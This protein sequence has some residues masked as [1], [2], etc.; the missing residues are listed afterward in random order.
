[1]ALKIWLPLNGNLTNNGVNNYTITK[2]NDV[3]FDTGG[4]LGK[5][6][7]STSSS[8]KITINVPELATMFGAGHKY[9]VA[10]WV[11]LVGTVTSGWVV[12]LGNTNTGLW[13]AKSEARWVWNE[14]DN[15]KRCYRNEIAS[16][17]TNWY[18]VVTVVDKTE[19]G[20]IKYWNYVDGAIDT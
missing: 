2:D 15:G 19:S 12:K 8:A 11:K 20:K 17:Y 9:S 6:A 1:M 4:K 5:Y 18:H 7:A 16:D 3:T 14:A 10:C 13:W